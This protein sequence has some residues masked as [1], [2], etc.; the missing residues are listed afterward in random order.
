L[1]TPL[2]ASLDLSRHLVPLFLVVCF[3]SLSY[4]NDLEGLLFFFFF[5]DEMAFKSK[6]R[7]AGFLTE[8]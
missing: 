8:G 7:E 1:Y 4:F 2:S 5:F 6:A 3:L